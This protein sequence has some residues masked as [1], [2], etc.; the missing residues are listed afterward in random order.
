MANKR[1]KPKTVSERIRYAIE[2]A[3]VTHY[4]ISKESGIEQSAL[5][6]FISGERGLSMEAI[7]ALAE[8]FGLELTEKP[9]RRS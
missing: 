4:R 3:D 5:S 8:H 2:T 6:R 7:D 1:N 9:K